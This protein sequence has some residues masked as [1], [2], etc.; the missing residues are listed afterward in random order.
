M[1]KRKVII[2]TNREVKPGTPVS[3]PVI[4]EGQNEAA[5][6]YVRLASVILRGHSGEV[7]PSQLVLSSH[8]K[9]RVEGTLYFLARGT[10][11]GYVLDYEIHKGANVFP[12][13]RYSG[14]Y[15][16]TDSAGRTDCMP[17]PGMQAE[18]FA[19]RDGEISVNDGEMPRLTYHSLDRKRPYIFPC[20]NARG[21]NILSQGL[22]CD[23]ARSHSHHAGVW[24]G[25]KDINGI[26]F[27]EDYGDGEILHVSFE[28]VRN[29]VI[30]SQ[31][32]ETLNWCCKDQ[33][34]MEEERIITVYRSFEQD[35]YTDIEMTFTAVCDLT[36]GQTP[37]GYLGFR[38]HSAM[39]PLEGRGYL[40]NSNLHIGEK[41]VIGQNADWCAF[42]SAGSAAAIFSHP[43]N[44]ACIWQA[45]D[46]GFFCPSVNGNAQRKLKKGERLSCKYRIYSAAL[47]DDPLEEVI[48][49]WKS[50]V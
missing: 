40:I 38:V 41:N 45:R 10:Q 28:E 25:H 42:I 3:V 43:M 39:S 49:A 27:W 17:Y 1:E 9:D 44:G 12:S 34:I 30:F 24:I 47:A 8:A 21:K 50:Y 32:R 7:I 2:K 36:F 13:P 35:T 20:Y 37:F 15:L 26:N 16:F 46:N 14:H 6:E 5:G 11:P 18:P 31:I 22:P 48:R 23:P 29:G 33:A 4:L 19:P